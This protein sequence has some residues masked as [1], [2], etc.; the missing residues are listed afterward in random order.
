MKR[1]YC[2]EF[3]R[4]VRCHFQ[5]LFDEYGFAVVVAKDAERDGCCVV[6]LRS[7]DCLFKFLYDRGT[8]EILVGALSTS[9]GQPWQNVEPIQNRFIHWFSI[10]GVIYFVEGRPWPSPQEL[11]QSGEALWA[12]TTDERLAT[13]SRMLRPVCDQVVKLFREDVFKERQ[14]EFEQ[15]YYS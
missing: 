6:V 14:K 15:F 1:E 4:Q 7:D 11:Q 3:L 12:M 5:Y 13:L 10:F 8:V 9:P 2:I